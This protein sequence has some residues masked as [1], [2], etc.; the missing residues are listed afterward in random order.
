MFGLSWIAKLQTNNRPSTVLESAD[1]QTTAHKNG[2]QVLK[3]KSAQQLRRL[4]IHVFRKVLHIGY[5]DSPFDS[6]FL[7][8]QL[9]TAEINSIKR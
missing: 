5:Q 9:L 4:W 6:P 7:N 1:L 8:A 2:T 3:D